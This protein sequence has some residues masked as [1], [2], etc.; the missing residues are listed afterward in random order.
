[1]KKDN[2]EKDMNIAKDFLQ[3]CHDKITEL[4]ISFI[5]L[6]GNVKKELKEIES[7]EETEKRA[8]LNYV[9]LWRDYNKL[10]K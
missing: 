9:L 3:H 8:R 2:L 1:M 7:W 5:P 10:K 4:E 6:S